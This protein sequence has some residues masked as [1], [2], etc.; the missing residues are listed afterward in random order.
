MS[1]LCDLVGAMIA[2]GREEPG[3]GV[4]GVSMAALLL[5]LPLESGGSGH[6][7]LQVCLEQAL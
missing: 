2:G 6:C 4:E 5:P 3:Q 1:R 7:G